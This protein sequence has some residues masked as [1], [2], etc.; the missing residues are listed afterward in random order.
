MESHTSPQRTR[1]VGWIA[2][3]AIFMFINGLFGFIV[4]LVALLKDDY[5]VVTDDRI[6]A[7]DVT[8]WGWINIVFS[9]FLMVLAAALIAGKPWALI[10][11]AVLIGLHMVAQFAFLNVTPVWSTVSIAVDALVIWAIVVHGR[12]AA[13]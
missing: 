5:F 4:G 1:W 3:G 7:F 9:V 12:E 10:I 8:T 2:F 13:T 6:V 11:S